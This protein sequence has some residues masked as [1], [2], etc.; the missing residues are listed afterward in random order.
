M[1]FSTKNSANKLPIPRIRSDRTLNKLIY[2]VIYLRLPI[3]VL[4]I[5]LLWGYKGLQNKFVQPQAIMVLGGSTKK[6]EREKFT[7]KTVIFRYT[8]MI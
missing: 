7:A 6:L 4:A 1:V 3:I 5:A 8:F 2:K